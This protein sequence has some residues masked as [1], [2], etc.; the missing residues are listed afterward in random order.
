MIVILIKYKGISD[1]FHCDYKWD[2]Y[3]RRVESN[4]YPCKSLMEIVKQVNRYKEWINR[5]RLG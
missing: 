2:C 4:K 3:K 1:C 5:S